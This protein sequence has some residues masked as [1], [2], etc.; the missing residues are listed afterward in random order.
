MAWCRVVSRRRITMAQKIE[1]LRA[2]DTDRLSAKFDDLVE[3]FH[4]DARF[5]VTPVGFV[6]AEDGGYMLAVRVEAT[7]KTT[8]EARGLDS[9]D[10]VSKVGDN[11][12]A[13]E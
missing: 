5:I 2:T 11:I 7:H 12:A 13:A 8:F 9:I 10:M 3:S 4:G 6:V 1:F